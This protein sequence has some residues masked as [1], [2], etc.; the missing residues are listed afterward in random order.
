MQ[1]SESLYLETLWDDTPYS[2]EN[3]TG[4]PLTEKMI[5]DAEEKLG[6]RLPRAYLDVLRSRNGGILD[7]CVFTDED[8]R[9][10]YAEGLYGID[11]QKTYSLMNPAFDT[12]FW[13]EEW[14]YP[15]GLGLVIAD[16]PSAGHDM[17][18]LD[19]RDC[20]PQGEPAVVH[21]DNE[22]GNVITTI[23]PDFGSFIRGLH[24]EPAV[25]YTPPAA[26]VKKE[27]PFPLPLLLIILAAVLLSVIFFIL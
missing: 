21:V 10:F 20:G 12:A 27:N 8:G 23:A 11:P 19:Y 9:D 5:R 26:P 1:E 16:T 18:F 7:K 25:E 22:L 13:V 17:F 2:E 6:Y 4:A 14:Q 3:Y 15:A 24:E